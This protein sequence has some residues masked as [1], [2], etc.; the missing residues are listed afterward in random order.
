[1]DKFYVLQIHKKCYNFLFI[2]LCDFLCFMI[3]CKEFVFL[4]NLAVN[5][6]KIVLNKNI[7]KRHPKRCLLGL[8]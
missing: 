7:A 4:F 3:L 6:Q 2:I 8:R 1:M 5:D